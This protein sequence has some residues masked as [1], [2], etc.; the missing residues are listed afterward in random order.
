[1]LGLGGLVLLGPAV[2][3]AQHV[4]AGTA[5]VL[6]ADGLVVGVV[7]VGERL[8]G[9]HVDGVALGRLVLRQGL[10]PEDAALDH[11]HHVEH[12]ADHALV[13]AQA[14]GARHRETRGA[15]GRDHP[16]FPVHRVRRRQQLAR[17]LAAH[18]V[19]PGRGDQLVGGIGL[20]ALELA[21]L[22]R[23]GIALDVRL[24]PIV[25]PRFIELVALDHLLGAGVLLLPDLLRR[26]DHRRFPVCA[27]PNVTL[28]RLPPERSE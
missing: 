10:V 4:V 23:A 25:Q 19:L 9:G 8:Q 27:C 24:H 15:E 14:V 3:L 5:E 2:D 6:Q 26:V 20:T 22:Q 11:V 1:M 18:D 17:R 12:G 7:Q 16:V 21:H 13:L 28:P